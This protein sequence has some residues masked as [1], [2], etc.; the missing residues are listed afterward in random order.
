MMMK[1]SEEQWELE[2]VR[3]LQ[4]KHRTDRDVPQILIA[5]PSLKPVP[6][7]GTRINERYEEYKRRLNSPATKNFVLWKVARAVEEKRVEE[8]KIAA[9]FPRLENASNR[10]AYFMACAKAAF[11]SCGLSWLEEEW[12]DA[13]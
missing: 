2:K 4:E 9:I 10:G 7:I 12:T 11:L 13:H 3:D 8:S 1:K 6:A 5:I